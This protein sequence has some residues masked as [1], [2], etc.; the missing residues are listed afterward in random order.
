MM[1]C[2][3]CKDTGCPRCR[4]TQVQVRNV[5]ETLHRDLKIAAARA[6]KPMN[7]WIIEA[8]RAALEDGK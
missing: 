4:K 3:N 5:P 8:I 6:G 2:V 7:A 1:I